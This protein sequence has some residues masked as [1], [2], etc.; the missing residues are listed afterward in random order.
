MRIFA[1]VCLVAAVAHAQPAPPPAPPPDP[2]AEALNE[3]GKTLYLEGKDYAGAAARFRAAIAISQDPRYYYNLCTALEKIEQWDAALAACEEV[4]AH[5]PRP[6]LAEKTG[7]RAAAIRKAT[8]T[9]LP[10]DSRLPETAPAVV[11]NP[12]PEEPATYRWGLGADLGI[13]HDISVGDTSLFAN[14]GLVLRLQGDLLIGARLGLG[15]QLYTRYA[16][17]GTP[18]G[19]FG[20]SIFE[21]GAGAYWHKQLWESL[22]FTPAAALCFASIAAHRDDGADSY[23]TIGLR[24]DAS[25]EWVFAGGMHVVS[26]TPLSLGAYLPAIGQI[27]GINT[28]ASVYGF[29]H[30]GST[31]AFTV[32]YRIR[33]RT[34][35]FPGLNL[36]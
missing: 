33:F 35:L 11:E 19:G 10:P 23:G 4:F 34:G 3:Q 17:F 22:Y 32:G 36:E 20:L 6:D 12:Y 8:K 7:R 16:S 29:D 1:L 31:W 28:D 26:L 24:L 2:R 15:I 25:F 9:P 5:D 27:S 14:N 13:V 18:A 30:G 21:L